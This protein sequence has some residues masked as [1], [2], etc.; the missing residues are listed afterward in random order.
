MIVSIFPVNLV[1]LSPKNVVPAWQRGFVNSRST[2]PILRW[3][4]IFFL[5]MAV[6]LTTLQLISYSRIRTNFPPG[7]IIGNI[8]VG[9]LDRQEAAQRILQTYS[10]PI[11]IHY[12][13]AVIQM[14]P[15]I[16]GFELDLESMLAAA[17]A[18]R[19]QESFWIGFWNHLWNTTQSATQIPLLSSISEDR[20]KT[21]LKN[22][23]AVRYDQPPEAAI[24]VPGSV[25]FKAGQQ[26]TSLDIDRAVPLIEDALRS[27]TSRVVNIPFLKTNPSRP[28]FQNLQILMQQVIDLAGFNGVAEVYLKDLQTNQELNF[29]YQQGANLPPEIAFTAASTI[30]IPIMVSVYRRTPEP[31][32]DTV[33]N[34]LESMIVRSDNPPAD[35]LMDEVIAK[36]R[37][38]LEV[39][40]DMQVL[41]LSNTFLAGYFYNGAP[42]LSQIKTPANQRTDINTQPDV[43]NQTTTLDMGLLLDDIY[44]CAQTGGGTF[45]A[46]FGG[47]IS[48]AEC[49]QMITYLKG[50]RIGVLIQAGLPEG[51]PI[52]HKHGWTEDVGSGYI[53]T[54]GDSSIAYTPGGNYILV[55]FMHDPAQLV[56]DP[57]NQLF[58]QLSQ[59]V[60]NYYNSPIQ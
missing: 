10:A 2:F 55:I 27:P 26:G 42:L 5:I 4:S 28:S 51:T 34:L 59:A 14:K 16:A 47:A 17:D 13:D 41:G 31:T 48:Q 37:G 24:P 40:A 50:N 32:P 39:T 12:G 19:S 25:I 52:A 21:Y 30:K 15:S 6:I 1:E 53:R 36:G 45:A 22:E 35:Q 8:P 18:Q 60:Y 20:L 11:E 38:P 57:I 54:I 7:Q 29:A 23:I 58:A 46:A 44:Q 49:Q 33:A 9:N 56:F 3:T 43:Y